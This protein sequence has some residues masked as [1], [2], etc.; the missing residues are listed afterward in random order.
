[1]RGYISYCLF[2]CN[3]VCVLV[4]LRISPARIKLAASNL[5]GGSSASWAG[6]FLSWGTLLPQKPK[7]GP[8][9][10]DREVLLRVYIFTPLKF[11]KWSENVKIGASVRAYFIYMPHLLFAGRKDTADFNVVWRR[12]AHLPSTAWLCVGVIAVILGVC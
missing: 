11:W 8:I 12:Y 9:G 2:V 3:F 7:I 10:Y 6:N 1:M 5:H 4:R